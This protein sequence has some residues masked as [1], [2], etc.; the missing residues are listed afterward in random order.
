MATPA[1]DPLRIAARVFNYIEVALWPILGILF[2]V[3]S[4]RR[5]GATR[6]D[7]VIAGITLLIFGA[8]DYLEAANGNE[9]W[10]PWWLFLWKAAC[11]SNLVLLMTNALQ[12]TRRRVERALPAEVSVGGHCQGES[13]L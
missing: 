7:C 3:I 13:S 2:L 10:R 6:R 12:R 9:W 1:D 4:R 8:S 5:R 11:V